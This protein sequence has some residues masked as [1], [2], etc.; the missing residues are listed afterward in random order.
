LDDSGEE[1]EGDGEEEEGGSKVDRSEGY[2]RRFSFSSPAI[3]KKRE[4]G[5]LAMERDM[6]L[7]Q[8][9][10]MEDERRRM[11]DERENLL[12][13]K[14][15][16]DI[17]KNLLSRERNA[18]RHSRGLPMEE[19]YAREDEKDKESVRDEGLS[20]SSIPSSSRRSRHTAAPRD[21][22]SR[23][24]EFDAADDEE[25]DDQ[26]TDEMPPRI[27]HA[28]PSSGGSLVLPYRHTRTKGLR[29]STQESE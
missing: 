18:W 29:E 16:V 22:S 2:S 13:E 7:H 8:A 25:K 9:Q 6:L 26:P 15:K 21:L 19:E 10:E 3:A 28:G 23:V 27:H 5:T 20:L 14:Q 11:E 12:L 4:K 1:G 17:E 24:L